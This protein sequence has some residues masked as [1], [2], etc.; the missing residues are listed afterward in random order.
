MPLDNSMD[1]VWKSHCIGWEYI[2][3]AIPRRCYITN[4][5]IWMKR[6]YRGVAMWTGPGEPVFDI[7]WVDRN[8]YLLAKIKGII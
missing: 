5:L 1:Y 7:R 6:G 8:E 3:S 2:F 4:K